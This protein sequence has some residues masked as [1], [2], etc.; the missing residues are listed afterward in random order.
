MC[1]QAFN[2]GPF[3]IELTIISTKIQDEKNPF[4]NDFI[5]HFLIQSQIFVK[6]L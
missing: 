4:Q 5:C 1:K 2:L 3:I 6:V